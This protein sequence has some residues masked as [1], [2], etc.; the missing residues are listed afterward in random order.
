VLVQDTGEDLGIAMAIAHGERLEEDVLYI[1]DRIADVA[2]LLTQDAS[3]DWILTFDSHQDILFD[4]TSPGGC[5]YAV[6]HRGM[7]L[8]SPSIE[9]FL[10]EAVRVISINRPS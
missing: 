2:L 8:A 7:P 4:N 6:R 9:H 1:V 10:R 5:W 3:E